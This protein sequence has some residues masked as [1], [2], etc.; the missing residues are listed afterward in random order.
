MGL[1]LCERILLF[2]HWI[3]SIRQLNMFSHSAHHIEIPFNSYNFFLPF[4]PLQNVASDIGEWKILCVQFFPASTKILRKM[5]MIL[6]VLTVHLQ[7]HH[8]NPQYVFYWKA[9]NFQRLFNMKWIGN[10]I[11][12]P[13]SRIELHFGIIVKWKLSKSVENNFQLKLITGIFIL[14]NSIISKKNIIVESLEFRNMRQFNKQNPVEFKGQNESL[15]QVENDYHFVFPSTDFFRFE[16]LDILIKTC[17]NGFSYFKAKK[18]EVDEMKRKNF[19]IINLF[20]HSN[21][22]VGGWNKG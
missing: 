11:S 16:R 22:L 15:S 21:P 12:S 10:L 6:N 17:F 3:P 13:R 1:W 9:Y 4:Y 7:T 14:Q 18:S 2:A 5:E 8:T 20:S 19:F